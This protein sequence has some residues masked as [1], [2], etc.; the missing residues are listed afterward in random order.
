M[1]LVCWAFSVFAGSVVPFIRSFLFGGCGLLYLNRDLNST[2]DMELDKNERSIK[3]KKL[4][5]CFILVENSIRSAG[6][7]IFK[8]RQKG[9]C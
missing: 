5:T 3:S 2:L 4:I 8:K 6:I 9:D 1:S 7:L